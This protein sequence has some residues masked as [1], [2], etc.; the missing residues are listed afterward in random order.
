MATIIHTF[1]YL[2]SNRNLIFG[3]KVSKEVIKP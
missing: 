3:R 2:T 1:I